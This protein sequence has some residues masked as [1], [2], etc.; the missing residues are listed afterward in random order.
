MKL[1]LAATA[2]A[3]S[4]LAFSAQAA[5][6]LVG[7]INDSTAKRAPQSAPVSNDTPNATPA[8][9]SRKQVPESPN[10]ANPVGTAAGGNRLD[11]G[12]TRIQKSDMFEE[13]RSSANQD[14]FRDDASRNPMALIDKR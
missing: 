1:N 5:E 9:Y 6:E 14:S 10:A 7:H 8:E 3:A 13:K 12:A 11:D 4:M 2:L